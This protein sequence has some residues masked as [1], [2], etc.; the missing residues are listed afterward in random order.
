[1]SKSNKLTLFRFA[2]KTQNLT[3]QEKAALIAIADAQG[4]IDGTC[5]ASI[6]TMAA[7]YARTER[8]LQRGIHGY[9]K[10]DKK[11][12]LKRVVAEGLVNRG[13]I[14]ALG[15]TKGGHHQN[16]TKWRINAEKLLEYL[17]EEYAVK[18]KRL[19]NP[20]QPTGDTT[21]DTAQPPRVTSEGLTGDKCT[22]DGCHSVTQPLQSPQK[23][24]QSITSAVDRLKERFAQK[25]GKVITTTAKQE[26]QLQTLIEA[27]NG[28]ETRA[29][30]VF[31]RIVDDANWDL[32]D[33][34]ASFL[35][36]R[37]RDTAIGLGAIKKQKEVDSDP[38]EVS[39]DQIAAMREQSQ[40]EH[41]EIMARFAQKEQEEVVALANIDSWF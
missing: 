5:W 40:R 28:T 1:M 18:L 14:Y 6:A 38:D 16:T 11:T 19:L 15:S 21:D 7:D 8:S 34:P 26:A 30:K 24:P 31:D 32:I 37:W 29:T 27:S 3:A 35:I 20:E 22:S 41:D 25:T 2:K 33:H 39:P 17:P 9:S 12:G 13:L 36:S 10:K 23:S 4:G